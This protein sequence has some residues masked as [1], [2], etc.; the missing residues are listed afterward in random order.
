MQTFP[1]PASANNPDIRKHEAPEFMNEYSP[2]TFLPRTP[3][4]RVITILLAGMALLAPPIVLAA[5]ELDLQADSIAK[6]RFSYITSLQIGTIGNQIESVRE[7]RAD[8]VA[9]RPS[10]RIATTSVTGMGETVDLLQLDADS[11]Y[12]LQRQ[13]IQGGSRLE[14]NYAPDR[15]TGLIQAA[16]QVINVDLALDAPAYA[17]DAGLDT[18]L[19][20]LPFE[21]GLSGELQA[22][23][24][25]V[26]IYVQRF[27]FKVEASEL[28]E[29]PAGSFESWPVRLQAVDDPDYRQTVWLST[30]LPRVFVQ[31]E[32]PIPAEAGGGVLLTQL[33]EIED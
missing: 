22:I 25:D 8:S 4:Y 24:T 5:S 23:E 28:I 1:K 18:L 6:G 11:L 2:R 10:L 33:I 12:P 30:S 14:L 27:S 7:I 31:A 21:E 26:E 20:G 17:G 16:G 15:V 32:A 13:I 3:A 19:G 9:G 29:T